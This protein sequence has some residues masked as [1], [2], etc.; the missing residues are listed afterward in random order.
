M[1]KRI[2]IILSISVVVI[3]GIIPFGY[4]PVVFVG[5]EPIFARDYNKNYSASMNYYDKALET[6]T[7]D[8]QI[9]Q[10]DEAKR[11]LKRAVLDN[12][13]E[14]ILINRELKRE[15]NHDD[16]KILIEK[17]MGEIS[18][19]RVVGEATETL[20]GFSLDE[21]KK[22]VLGPQARKEILDDRLFLAGIDLGE[23]MKSV[24]SQAKVMIFLP[25]FEWKNG[26]VIAQ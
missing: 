8:S 7:K 18:D 9:L 13:V 10:A 3:A 26:E 21:F 14:N 17:K 12:L 23:K 6:Y 24:R 1:R 11:E 2:L 4:Y 20:Y 16:L 25:G 22:L 19:S 15:L 5:L